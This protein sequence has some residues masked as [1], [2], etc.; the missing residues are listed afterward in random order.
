ME[1]IAPLVILVL[2]AAAVV[3]VLGLFSMMRGGEPD[4]AAGPD[5][6]PSDDTADRDGASAADPDGTQRS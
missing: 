5:E 3:V 2:A 6:T 4:D 1:T